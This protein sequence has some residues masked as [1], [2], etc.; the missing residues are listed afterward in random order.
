MHFSHAL[1][2]VTL[3]Y[4]PFLVAPNPK[5]VMSRKGEGS[6]RAVGGY[7]MLSTRNPMTNFQDCLGGLCADLVAA[8]HRGS[9][10]SRLDRRNTE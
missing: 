1:L 6:G 9:C 3:G 10:A 2:G 4:P 8:R 7:A 5:E